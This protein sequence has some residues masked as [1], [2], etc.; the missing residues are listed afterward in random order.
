MLGACVYGSLN[1]V[2]SDG[3]YIDAP[4]FIVFYVV[5]RAIVIFIN[6]NIILYVRK[7]GYFFTVVTFFEEGVSTEIFSSR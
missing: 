1:C 6:Y 4:A 3:R 2:Y 7:C 5:L